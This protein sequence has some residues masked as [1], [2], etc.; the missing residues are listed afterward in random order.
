M[1]L[2][3]LSFGGSVFLVGF[4][5]VFICLI[6][7]MCYILFQTIFFKKNNK[8]AKPA[9]TTNQNKEASNDFVG[10]L[11]MDESEL[12]AAISA[13]VAVYLGTAS[14]NVV[15]KSYRRIGANTPAWRQAGRRDQI[16]NKF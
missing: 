11:R 4:S 7:L 9:K 15:I 5:V 8:K 12:V 2:E 16:F 3:Q 14:G 6:L 13:A 1:L 10:Q